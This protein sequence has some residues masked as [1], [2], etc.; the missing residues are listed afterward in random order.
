MSLSCG[1]FNSEDGDREY[2]NQDLSNFLEGLVEDGIYE[3]I[4]D[5][6]MVSASATPDMHILVGKGRAW[7]NGTW[8]KIDAAYQVAIPAADSVLNRIDA[9][10]LTVNK[11]RAVR[12][13]YIEIISGT[14][15]VD[16]PTKPTVQNE[17]DIYRHVL[18]YVTVPKGSTAITQ[19]QIE[20]RVGMGSALFSKPIWQNVPTT[21]EMVAQWQVQ[22]DEF[23]DHI[24]ETFDY[25]AAG[26]LQTEIDDLQTAL[27][28][29]SDTA[30]TTPGGTAESTALITSGAVNAGIANEATARTNAITSAANSLR[31]D[32]TDGCNAVANAL[33]AQGVTPTK[34]G[35]NYTPEEFR[36]AMQKLF[37]QGRAA[38]SRTVSWKCVA[39]TSRS[40][41]YVVSADYYVNNVKVKSSS[42]SWSTSESVP[43]TKTDSG[44]GTYTLAQV[45]P[46][47]TSGIVRQSGE[48]GWDYLARFLIALGVSVSKQ[49]GDHYGPTS[50][51]N[52]IPNIKT[53][54]RSYPSA[55]SI[56]WSSYLKNYVYGS[57]SSFIQYI[58]SNTITFTV[59][60]SQVV[61][62]NDLKDTE[63][64]K[65]LTGNITC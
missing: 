37:D 31:Q 18:A 46:P 24:H 10:C 16:A 62:L 14:G 12:D 15:S 56:A 25:D 30:D 13:N 1:F 45:V 32:F 23:M 42:K 21:E 7:F 8:T 29:I 39:S 28:N 11:T 64:P 19:A 52:A 51:V 2:F 63:S 26:H 5:K 38:V 4:D 44:N 36:T 55:R 27:N 49:N 61:N 59:K 35:T 41:T 22:F 47:S 33:I 53:K 58:L 43:S 9:I 34:A 17:T 6:M 57:G 50:L 48:T 60:G 20:N 65:T 54:G 40:S 3:F